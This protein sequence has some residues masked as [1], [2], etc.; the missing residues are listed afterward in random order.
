MTDVGD[1]PTAR[2]IR[3]IT[4]AGSCAVTP[5]QRTFQVVAAVVTA[6][7][8][9]GFRDNLL[10]AIPTAAC[11]VFLLIGAITGWCPSGLLGSAVE[12]VTGQRRGREPGNAFGIPE[13]PTPVDRVDA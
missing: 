7:L 2:G 13:A 8:A 6:S 5:G 3:R 12:R 1:D 10:C 9:I 11:S 4:T